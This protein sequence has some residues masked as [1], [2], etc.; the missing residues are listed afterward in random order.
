ME[1]RTAHHIVH[2]FEWLLYLSGFLFVIFGILFLSF[3][4]ALPNIFPSFTS[5]AKV[6][7]AFGSLTGFV[8]IIWGTACFWIGHGV[9]HRH[10]RARIAFL[11]LSV[12]MLVGVFM[13]GYTAQMQMWIFGLLAVAALWFFGVQK[14]V[15]GQF[16]TKP[17][18]A[19]VLEKHK[20]AP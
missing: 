6:H 1:H 13:G 20:R 8:F 7:S 11:A 17:A 4:G 10:N 15:V 18:P 9:H 2:T 14:E 19:P 12:V 5:L 3:Q 16:R